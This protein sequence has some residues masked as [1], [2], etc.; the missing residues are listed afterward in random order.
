MPWREINAMDQ[1]KEFIILWKSQQFSVTELSEMFNISRTTA[2]KYLERFVK[3]GYKGL[4]EE[5]RNPHNHPNKTPKEIEEA[6]IELRKK[7]PRWGAGVIIDILEKS[8][9]YEKLPSATTGNRILKDNDLIKK[10][11]RHKKVEMQKPIFDPQTPNEVWSAD[12]KGK[13]KMKNGQYCYPLTIA[14]SYSRYILAAK[15]LLYANTK[16]SKPVFIKTFRKYGLPEQ[17]HTDNGAPFGSIHALGRLTSFAVWLLDIGVMPVYSDPGHPEQNGRHERMHRE[18]KGEATRPPGKNLQAQQRKLNKFIYEYNE[19]RPY[20]VLG[21]MTAASVHE[22]SEREYP[23]VIRDWDYPADYKVRYVCRNG[24]IRI[25]KANW[26]FVST[27]L[28]GKHIGLEELGNGIFRIYY[29]NF[30]LGYLDEKELKVYDILDYNY[31]M[32]V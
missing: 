30:F 2:Y 10:R 26:I 19:V 4:E 13:F 18:L 24:A 12:F 16:Q 23:E 3:Q 7:H 32:R 5:T 20:Q 15:G 17:L 1:K 14:D 29:R 28:M 6:I 11:R 25:G 31:V 22:V 27:A 8:G 9:N 21:K